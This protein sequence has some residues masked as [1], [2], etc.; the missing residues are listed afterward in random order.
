M[1]QLLIRKEKQFTLHFAENMETGPAFKDLA[2]SCGEFELF[3][4][5]GFGRQYTCRRG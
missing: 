4:T 2:H 3:I 5:Q 1:L